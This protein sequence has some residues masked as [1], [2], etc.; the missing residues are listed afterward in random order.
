MIDIYIYIYRYLIVAI[1][2]KICIEILLL[3]PIESYME[4]LQS[5]MNYIPEYDFFKEELREVISESSFKQFRE[6]IEIQNPTGR[7][8]KEN[9]PQHYSGQQLKRLSMILNE[10]YKNK[11]KCDIIAILNTQEYKIEVKYQAFVLPHSKQRVKL[12][13]RCLSALKCSKSRRELRENG[14]DIGEHN[15][16]ISDKQTFFP[17]QTARE[18]TRKT[19]GDKGNTKNMLLDTQNIH[20]HNKIAQNLIS[21]NIQKPQPS[22]LP[23]RSTLQP[24]TL[25]HLVF[26]LEAMKRLRAQT[27]LSESTKN[28][29]D[30]KIEHLGGKT[31]TFTK[32]LQ[33]TRM[34]TLYDSKSSLLEPSNFHTNVHSNSSS[35]GGETQTNN[36][37]TSKP[38][39]TLN[40]SKSVKVIRSKS[41]TQTPATF[42]NIPKGENKRTY[43]LFN[44]T[45][46]PL[47]KFFKNGITDKLKLNQLFAPTFV[48]SRKK[49]NIEKKIDLN[50]RKNIQK[51]KGRLK[52]KQQ[53]DLGMAIHNQIQMANNST[54][55]LR[56]KS[57]PR[58]KSQILNYSDAFSGETYISLRYIIYIYIYIPI[59]LHQIK[60]NYQ[61][62]IAN[63]DQSPP[64]Q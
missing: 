64:L 52:F 1:G 43:E 57:N 36:L 49:Q 16:D 63:F 33:I 9:T 8:R 21:I 17:L 32:A 23:R 25:N 24:N 11:T 4:F 26:D 18:L 35:T 22:A 59:A 38:P 60:V 28:I 10:I 20:R 5:L 14:R 37:S 58:L 34:K 2:L 53:N 31:E 51:L 30:K 40:L 42:R 3:R 56:S 39:K 46:D 62:I 19:L 48:K 54:N 50:I 44:H 41:S 13:K 47:E 61:L 15:M 45:T 27:G 12:Q 6:E 55:M 29:R 7:L